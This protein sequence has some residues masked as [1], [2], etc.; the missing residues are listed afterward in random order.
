MSDSE[1]IDFYRHALTEED[2]AE[3][4]DTL[5]GVF[6]TTGPRARAFE[7]KLA[8]YA[9]VKHAVTTSSWTMGAFL[10][11]KAW[12]IGDRGQD[13]EVITTPMTF[14]ASANVILHT[15]A[16]PVF[17]DIDPG[18]GNLDLDMVEAAI[19][20]KTR[21]IL[22]VH[23][24][25]CMVDMTALRAI[26][27]R[28]G[29]KIL[30]D[31]A[32]CL[33]GRRGGY[34]PGQLGDAAAF[35]FYATKNLACGEGGAVVTDDEVLAEALRKL[36]LHGM[37]KSAADRYHGVYQH[38]DMCALGYKANM[39]DVLA[40]LLLNQIDRLDENLARREKLC[41]VYEQGFESMDGVR[42]PDWPSEQG[43]RHAR[44]LMTIQVDPARRDETL[45]HL[46]AKGVGV[47]VNFRALTRLEWYR[48]TFGLRPDAFPR[49]TAFGDGTITLPLYP[50]LEGAQV[51]R[52]L[53]VLQSAQGR[54]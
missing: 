32:H 12:G 16:R 40:A 27:D 11:L 4:A 31:A 35:S 45:A 54:T 10:T 44:H 34:G 28:H 26:A 21:A 24:Y 33:E 37:S 29:V 22:P 30:E 53:S 3:V 46:Q 5:R 38:W 17:V 25:G 19:T 23:L 7:E 20:E 49:A 15:G 1:R 2:I 8:G 48:D 51:R 47:A 36:R 9:G 43:F 52:V 18:T 13:D 41:R 6:L 39:P 42:A 50:S 14:I